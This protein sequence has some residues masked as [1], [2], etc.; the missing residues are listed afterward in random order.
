MDSDR[1]RELLSAERARIEQ[2]LS[3]LNVDGPQESDDRTDPGD[4]GSE[5]LY[6]DEFDAGR[7]EDLHTQLAALERADGRVG[8]AP[9]GRSSATLF[10][11]A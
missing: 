2:A 5:D 7:E 4:R 9:D 8:A 6:Q 1:A 11:T 3:T 10:T